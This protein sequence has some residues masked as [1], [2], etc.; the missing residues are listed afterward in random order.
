[1]NKFDGFVA[2]WDVLHEFNNS[3]DYLEARTLQFTEVPHH[4]SGQRA[5]WVSCT[6]LI[7]ILFW[8]PPLQL[9]LFGFKMTWLPL[10]TMDPLHSSDSIH[11]YLKRVENTSQ[12]IVAH[13]G[14]SWKIPE[15]ITMM[16]RNQMA[17]ELQCF[18]EVD[19]TRPLLSRHTV[20]PQ[21]EQRVY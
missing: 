13:G 15:K 10:R 6:E 20:E 16:I 18:F 17:D 9:D 8:S 21:W 7:T 4:L 11:S 1:M 3:K 5:I 12:V 14:I 2:K 19:W